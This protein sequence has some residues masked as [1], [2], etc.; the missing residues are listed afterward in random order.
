MLRAPDRFSTLCPHSEHITPLS[1]GSD[2]Y[3]AQVRYLDTGSRD[4]DDTLYRWLA[5]V[6]PDA[7]HFGVQTG[8]FSY[9]ALFALQ[10]ELEA[11]LQRQGSIHLVVGANESGVRQDDLEAVLDLYDSAALP[12]S[13]CTLTLVAADDVLMHSKT[14]YVEQT[15]GRRHALVG[16]ANLT[17]PGISRN[18]EAAIALDSDSDPNAPFSEIRAAIER[19]RN[20][21]SP[22]R[23]R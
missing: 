20:S 19:W 10:N 23:T 6:L 4:P 7:I 22:T 13:N 9:D 16:S 3:A 17:N 12:G 2:S 11:L 15:T 21:E 5:R 1:E 18:L 14:F 8:Y